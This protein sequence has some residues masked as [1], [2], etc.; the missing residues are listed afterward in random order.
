MKL[1]LDTHAVVWWMNDDPRLPPGVIERLEAGQ[2]EVLLSA[3]VVWE[4]AIKRGLGK[5]EVGSGYVDAFVAAGARPLPVTLAHAAA[6]E[7]L[8]PHHHDPFDRLLVA[9]AQQEQAALVSQDARLRSYSVE[10]IW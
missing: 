8:F 3:V 7:R 6:V 4:I 1:L 2:D 9:Q 10:L 5:L